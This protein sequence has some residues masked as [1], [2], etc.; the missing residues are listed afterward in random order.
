[1]K[2]N[3]DE[4]NHLIYRLKHFIALLSELVFSITVNNNQN[5][6]IQMY[7]MKTKPSIIERIIKINI[8]ISKYFRMNF[9]LA[10]S[11]ILHTPHNI[12]KC[13]SNGII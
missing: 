2:I 12:S 3:L 11:I 13:I 5:K 4:K 6:L 9:Y 7:L 1:M 10:F 8:L